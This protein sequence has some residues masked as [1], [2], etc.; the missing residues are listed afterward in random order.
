M[1]EQGVLDHF[2]L[3]SCFGLVSGSLETSPV[4]VYFPDERSEDEY[5]EGLLEADLYRPERLRS[6]YAERLEKALTPVF[7]VHV[8]DGMKTTTCVA[9][10]EN[11]DA[12]AEDARR[13]SETDDA[14][15]YRVLGAGGRIVVRAFRGRLVDEDGNP[16]QPD[17]VG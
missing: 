13:R 14:G 17:P 5:Y 6:Y 9:I 16:L 1:A 3:W 15:L 11:P 2:I 7:T 8:W 12:A 4:I 10:H